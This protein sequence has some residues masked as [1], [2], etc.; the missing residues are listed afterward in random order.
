MDIKYLSSK[1]HMRKCE[2]MIEHI[3]TS[4]LMADLLTKPLVMR[5]FKEHVTSMGVHEM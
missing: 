3:D 1:D 5:V 2:I 4:M